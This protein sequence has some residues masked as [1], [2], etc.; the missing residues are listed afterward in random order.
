M[1]SA[2]E[3]IPLKIIWYDSILT[4][5]FIFLDINR[6]NSKLLVHN[7]ISISHFR[8]YQRIND[9]FFYTFHWYYLLKVDANNCFPIHCPDYLSFL[10]I[11]YAIILAYKDYF[12]LLEFPEKE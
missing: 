11:C 6:D 3:L 8:G 7:N 2:I 4:F 1:Q 5:S 10:F 12:P 9:F